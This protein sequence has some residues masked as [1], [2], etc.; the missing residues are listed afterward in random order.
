MSV[1][2]VDEFCDE[3]RALHSYVPNINHRTTDALVFLGFCARLDPE[4]LAPPVIA[5]LASDDDA[6]LSLVNCIQQ[7][8]NIE[9][10]GLTLLALLFHKRIQNGESGHDFTPWL[11][12]FDSLLLGRWVKSDSKVLEHMMHSILRIFATIDRHKELLGFLS[13]GL[14][15]KAPVLGVLDGFSDC[16]WMRRS[17]GATHV[18]A[19]K[20]QWLV[21]RNLPGT[22]IEVSV[23]RSSI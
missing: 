11:L 10:L 12:D 15:I 14:R 20:E 3:R 1:R 16:Y 23:S 6:L 18:V 5:W 17:E 4:M 8:H 7:P 2:Q 13:R 21:F 19:M 9:R 22:A